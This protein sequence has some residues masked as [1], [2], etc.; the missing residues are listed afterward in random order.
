MIR[1]KSLVSIGLWLERSLCRNMGVIRLILVQYSEL[2]SES[3]EVKLGYLLIKMLRKNVNLTGLVLASWIVD[4]D[5]GEHLVG[6]GVGHHEGRMASGAPEVEKS[7]VGEDDDPVSVWEDPSVGLRLDLDFLDFWVSL[8]SSHVELVIE[9]TDVSY[10]GVV[11]H[12]LHMV[13]CDNSLVTSGGDEDVDLA[14]D[15]FDLL[16]LESFHA[17]LESANWVDL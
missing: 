6:E 9:V 11:L 15:G 7:S 12:L 2:G 16:D 14:Y 8:E 3:S 10:D 5:L 17:G 13:D 4:G 1:S